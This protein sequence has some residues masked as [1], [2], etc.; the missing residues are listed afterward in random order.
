METVNAVSN[1]PI[2]KGSSLSFQVR[3]LATCVITIEYLT[4]P[5][6]LNE[7]HWN[8]ELYTPPATDGSLNTFIIPLAEGTLNYVK[9]STETTSIRHGDCYVLIDML[10][11]LAGSP[12]IATLIQR[13]LTTFSP[14]FIPGSTFEGSLEGI[15]S[16]IVIHPADPAA[17]NQFTS[18]VPVNT[19]W[20][21]H[22][23]TGYFLTGAAAANRCMNLRLTTGGG[24]VL[25]HSSNSLAMTAS[26]SY[27]INAGLQNSMTNA[28]GASGNVPDIIVTL[29]LNDILLMPGYKITS[30]IG[31]IQGADQITTIY[32]SIERWIC[33]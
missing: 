20:R 3:T 19:I 4:T 15:G 25:Y 11:S 16:Y 28:N 8:R 18:T 21:V 27:V 17:G 1:T 30:N 33:S 10:Q 13:Y 14:I 6:V 23:I 9:V 12:I 24:N 29:P 26:L 2:L 22:A 32:I 31:N 7:P 5:K